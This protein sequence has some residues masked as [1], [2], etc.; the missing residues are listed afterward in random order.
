MPRILNDGLDQ[1]TLSGHY[2]FSGTRIADLGASDYTLVSIVCDASPSVEPFRDDMIQ[3]IKAII[4]ACQFSPRADNLLV[5]LTQFHNS[6]KE[7]HGFKLLE[8][9]HDG[10]YDKCLK[11]SGSTAVYDAAENGIEATGAYARDLF[12]HNFAVN[13]IVF[14]ITDGEDNASKLTPGHIRKTLAEI[15]KDEVLE[16]LITV[17]VGVNV[18]DPAMSRYLT[19][20]HAQAGFTQYVELENADPSTLARLADFLSKSIM[21]QSVA[22]GTGGQSRL[23]VF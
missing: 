17:L 19:D 5:R 11:I 15:N 6:I 4:K 3:A 2:G 16:S 14:V 22:L 21:S 13:G 9:C 8:N 10:D 7:V 23:L 12:R 20:F 1:H 18:K